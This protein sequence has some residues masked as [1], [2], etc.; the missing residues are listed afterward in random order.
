M[1]P[2]P[3]VGANESSETSI[4]ARLPLV[5]AREGRLIRNRY[6]A[7]IALP[8]LFCAALNLPWHFGHVPL[9]RG[10]VSG[11]LSGWAIVALA[12]YL[13][14][15]NRPAFIKKMVNPLVL[16]IAYSR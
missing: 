15:D 10:L 3:N 2:E 6:L 9:K 11:G 7:H 14:R 5:K 12:A 1:T 13:L 4:T 8:L 16:F